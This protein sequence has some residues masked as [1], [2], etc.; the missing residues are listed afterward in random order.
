M[1]ASTGARTRD[2]A[3]QCVRREEPTAV[4]EPPGGP[5]I[6]WT[7]SSIKITHSGE[8]ASVY[9][10][11]LRRESR[12]T[13]ATDWG[14]VVAISPDTALMPQVLEMTATTMSSSGNAY[15]AD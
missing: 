14:S 10:W 15:R 12:Q 11:L 13:A 1:G 7:S 6:L 5:E 8:L 3:R 4:I 2:G 9:R